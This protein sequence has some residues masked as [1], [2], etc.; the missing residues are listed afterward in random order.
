[1]RARKLSVMVGVAVIIAGCSTGK[2]S[3]GAQLVK[4]VTA[5]E[6][7]PA[8]SPEFRQVL[9]ASLEARAAL[10]CAL[11]QTLDGR[12]LRVR[13]F[14]RG[15][16]KEAWSEFFDYG[17]NML[18]VDLAMGQTGWDEYVTFMF[19]LENGIA[20]PQHSADES[21]PFRSATIPTS[22]AAGSHR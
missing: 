22:L 19:E 5:A 20:E 18:Y 12:H 1:M 10:S 11:A 9:D 15:N 4:A 21:Q 16:P 17:P 7:Q 14:Y 13:Y 2:R 6:L 3:R 8:L